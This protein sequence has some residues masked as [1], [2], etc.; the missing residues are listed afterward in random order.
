MLVPRRRRSPRKA[1]TRSRCTTG[2]ATTRSRSAPRAR[3]SRP[4]RDYIYPWTNQWSRG[5]VQPGTRSPRPQRNDID[6]ARANLFAMHNRMHD[7]S[8][9]PR[10]HRDGVE[11]ADGNFG[12][13]GAGERPRAGQRPGRRHGCSGLA[14][15]DNANQITPADGIA[16]D[17][18]HVPV[19]ADRGLV[20]RAVRR[21]RLRHVGDRARVHPR[22]LQPHGRPGPNAGLSGA[23]AGAMGESWSDLRDRVPAR[24]RLR[25]AAGENPFAIGRYVTGDQQAGIR[26]YD[27]NN[28]PAQL[29][30]RRLRL[31]LQHAV[32]AHAGARRRRDL[33]RHQ[34]RH[35]PGVHRPLR[36]RQ[37][38]ACRSACARGELAGDRVPGQPALGPAR[39]RRA[40]ADGQRRRQHGRRPR[41]DA[42]RRPD[43][44]RRRQP[45]P[46]VERVRRARPRARARSA[47]ARPTPTRCRASRRRS[48]DEATVR[49][50]PAGAAG[51]G[52]RQLFVGDYEARA[53]P[54][55]DTDPGDAARRHVRA[56]AR[57]V[58]VRRPRHRL[59]RDAAR[60]DTSGPGSCAI[61]P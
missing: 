47:T 44:L 14:S 11:H 37:R 31:R 22:D 19:A 49:F 2:S 35:P 56:R 52:R 36:R 30:R 4:D 57:H 15:R 60:A 5:A 25:P 1:T 13:G 23:Q 50:R 59:R 24:E 51:H 27:M 53:M 17:H 18:Q 38:G 55:A 45:G 32:R 61:W 6:A 12:R 40:A 34:L 41:R 21:R 48:L 10:L 33:E 46:A 28:E 20:L 39:V 54:V 58:R 8:L 43:P 9:P 3:P 7:W 42:R 16:A 29:L 26:N